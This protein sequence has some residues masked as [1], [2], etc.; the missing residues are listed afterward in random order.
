MLQ[1][2]IESIAVPEALSKL[3]RFSMDRALLLFDRDSGLNALCE[4]TETAH[5]RLMAPRV[6]QFGITNRCNLACTFC[7]RDLTADSAW[8]VDSAFNFLAELANWGVLEVAFGGG[9]P[10]LFPNFADLINRLY[11]QTPLAINFTTNGLALSAA[12]LSQIRGKY[13]QI[14]LSL[15]DNNDWRQKVAMLVQAEARFG[16]NYLVTPMRLAQ[17][18]KTV[19]ELTSLGCRD[20]LLLSYN[21]ADHTMHLSTNENADLR[22]RVAVLAK[23]LQNQCQLKLDVCWGERMAG[24]DRLFEKNDCGAGREFIVLTSEKQLQPCSFHQLKIPVVDAKQ[25]MDLWHNNQEHLD[26]ASVLPGCARL[27][28]YGLASAEQ[29]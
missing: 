17:L 21:G 10:W 12:R 2:E 14:R 15:Y 3:R 4:G 24:I 9:E 18:E 23:I 11:D 20:I 1:P 8:T 22:R 26:Q 19:F 6:V 28:D 5:L 7:S 25:V 27:P 16:V 13:G 29:Q